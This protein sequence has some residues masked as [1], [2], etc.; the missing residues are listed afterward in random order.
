MLMVIGL[1]F[2]FV[3]AGS[4]QSVQDW[5][6]PVNLSKSGAASN[7]SLVV[8]ANGVLH[9]IWVDQFDGYKYVQSTDKGVNWSAPVTVKYPFTAEAAPPM[10]FS[11]ARGTI[12][13]FWLTDQNKLS[14]AQTIPDN[15]DSPASWRIRIDLDSAV[16]D[17]DAGMDPQGRMHVAYVKNPAP[18]PGTAGVYYKRSA[19]G[20]SSWAAPKL[21]YESPYFR[22]LTAE[23]AR[24]RLA[25]SDTPEGERV[26]VVWDDRPQKRIFVSTSIDGGL[27][28]DTVKEMVA[29]Q[30]NFGFRTPYNA[31]I[32]V[33]GDK[34][35]ATWMVGDPGARCTPYSWSSVDGGETWGEQVPILSESAQCPERADFI[36]IDPAYS[37]ALY[38]IQGDLSLSAWNGT[39]WSNPEI[40]VGP[41]S[42]TNLATFDPVELGC[43]QAV[44]YDGYLF[45]VGCD[46]TED[47]SASGDIWFVVRQLDPLDNLFPL[48][49][50]W[51]G[52][53]NIVTA[54]RTL[55]SLTSAADRAGNIHAVWIQSSYLPTDTFTPR[56][57]YSRWNGTEWTSPVPI[58]TNLSS[59]PQS[60]AL[61]IDSHQRLLLL[62]VNPETGELVFTWSSSERANIPLEWAQPIVLSSSSKLTNSPDMLVDAADRTAIAY[63]VTLNEG[64]G[65][66]VIQS[67]GL[68]ETW[69][70]P[71]KVF[72]AVS[73]GWEM[74]DQP[75]LAVS[76]DGTLHLLFTRFALL[77]E[78]Q[79]VGLYYSRSEDGGSTWIPAET[80]TEQPVQWSEIVES[81]EE[82]HRLWQE[83]DR[84]VVLTNHQFSVDG[85]FTWSSAVKI[86]TEAT[87]DS[88]PAVTVDGT[89]TLHF[90]HIIDQNNQILQEWELREERWQSLENRKVSALELNS[91]AVIDSGITSEGIIYALLRF[92]SE[93]VSDSGIETSI[94]SFHRSLKITE[95]GQAFWASIST[96]STSASPTPS[97]DVQLTDTPISP[98]AGLNDPQSRPNKN[99]IGLILIASVVI[100]LLV[101]V[102]PRRDNTRKFK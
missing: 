19:D 47:G 44:P 93:M 8:D 58:I 46:Q 82:I 35:L 41:S 50:E 98:L 17:F 16:Y 15:L 39:Q 74:V 67:A 43:E 80:V 22:S 90:L 21:L 89:G 75:R 42:I 94:L 4:A 60:L 92:E 56:I 1:L 34:V 5:S 77:G 27:N 100:L 36:P 61:Q 55:S 71:V 3:P 48:P 91:P 24:I 83:K 25:V 18:V 7:P 45:V 13:I 52:D 62:W 23:N 49:S 57:E 86:P 72:D 33:M 30:S 69:S 85:G 20:G 76:S 66:Y 40:Q 63:A 73:E 53:A 12:H 64:R 78:P 11:D 87:I 51:S 26:Y 99:I 97:V 37:V 6:E 38:T 70:S 9:V 14:Y 59:K 2:S 101:I 88:S 81:Q 29:P 102:I 65:I 54:P 31:D 10:L 96:P 32:D 68:G 79:P 28:W 84:Q 95:P